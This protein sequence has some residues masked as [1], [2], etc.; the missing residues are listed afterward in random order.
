M[1]IREI[2]GYVFA[3]DM[4]KAGNK[5]YAHYNENKKTNEFLKEL[6]QELRIHSN[7]L[8]ESKKGNNSN[9]CGTWVHPLVAIHLAQWISPEFYVWSIKNITK[10]Y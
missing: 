3:T 7:V 9:T 10:L 1:K 5:K 8:I 4:C 2:D 6:A